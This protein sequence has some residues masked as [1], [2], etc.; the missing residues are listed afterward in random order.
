MYKKKFLS[1]QTEVKQL[2]HLMINSLYSNREIFIRELISNAVDA[3]DKLHYNALNNDALYEGDQNLFIEIEVNNKNNILVI[4]D[5]GI[6]MTKEEVISNLG[7]IA[8][9]GTAD[10][11]AKLS[12]QQKKDAKLI[13]QFGVGFYSAFIVSSEVTVRTRLA[14]TK[15]KNGT[16][17]YSKGEGEFSI[18]PLMLNKHGTEIILKL[19]NNAKEF[20]EEY[21]IKEIIKKYSDHINIPVKM[22]TVQNSKIKDKYG[23]NLP[24]WLS[25]NEANALWKKNKNE[26][27]DDEY[28]NFYKHITNDY[29]EPLTWSHN[30]VEGNLEYTSLLYLPSRAPI[31]IYQKEGIRGLK[32][33]VQRIFIMDNIDQFLPIYLRF[34]KGVIDSNDLS[35]NVSREILQKNPQV[36]KIKSALTKRVL[37]MFNKLAKDEKNYQKFFDQFGS[38]LKEGLSEDYVNHAN[39]ASLLRFYTT[40]NDKHIQNQTLDNYISR[41][42]EGQHKIYYVVSDSFKSACNS[43]HIEIFRKK[44]IEVLLL[45][46]RIDE[47]V[48]MNHLT[49]F[50][51]KKFSDISKGDLDL[52][53]IEDDKEKKN[54]IE[55]TKSKENLISRIKKVLGDRVADVRFT[56]RLV[57][58][59]ACIVISEK[60]MGFQMRRIMEAANQ[61]LPNTKPIFEINPQHLIIIK[62]EKNIDQK[63]N[64]LIEVLFNQA[65]LAKGGTLED[66]VN[67][68]KRINNLLLNDSI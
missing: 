65:I 41:M 16:Q 4:R 26:I 31:D 56:H 9:S 59:P 60:D 10:F 44:G 15:F 19:K 35:I 43:P 40:Y 11:L 34:I 38:I 23:K 14:G 62:L 29:M 24:T 27:S 48:M 52:G 67:Y 57:D 47:W 54:L 49:E 30:K 45:V 53:N 28:K 55:H 63:F 68:I 3:C 12:E 20:S 5:N 46:D 50:K 2:L 58:S 61:I 18:E 33:Y 36:E 7:T 25:V 8:K 21:K 17:W 13:G 39:I 32:L 37:D 1:F 51:N 6:G 22:I 42:K 66:P 64:D